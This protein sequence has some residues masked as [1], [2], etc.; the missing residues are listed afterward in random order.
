MPSQQQAAAID[1]ITIGGRVI[2][3]PRQIITL[4]AYCTSTTGPYATFRR[5]SP[6]N[7]T[8]GYQVTSGKTLV[9]IGLRIAKSSDTL[10][11]RFYYGDT[12]RGFDSASDTTSP[13]GFANSMTSLRALASASQI[14]EVAV[15]A[16]VP[17]SKYFM[18][19]TAGGTVGCSFMAFAY[20]E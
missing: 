5:I 9:I 8:A 6:A 13:T 4:V 14:T 15:M 17:A 1:T 3:S 12:D 19:Q 7:D 20:E 16:R 10:D 18:V 2:S 11:C